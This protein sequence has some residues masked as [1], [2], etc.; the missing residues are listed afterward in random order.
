MKTRTYLS[1]RLE[2]LC[3]SSVLITLALSGGCE[4][5]STQKTTAVRPVKTMVVSAGEDVRIRSFP[6][7]VEAAKRVEL[8]FQVSGLLIELP[9]REGQE[10]KKGDLIGQI[11]KD[12]F[13]ARLAALQGQLDQARAELDALRLGERP[14]ERLR[15]E[16]QVRAA[17][18]RLA[19][20]RTERDR[21]APLVPRGAISRSELELLETQYQIAQE[22]LQAAQQM[23][24]K[25]LVARQEDLL[26]KEAQIRGLEG[27]VV[28]ANIQVNDCTLTAPFDGVIAQR[29]V[30]Q[31]QNVRAKEPIVRFQDAE[32]IEIAVDVP[33]AVMATD[34][35]RADILQLFAEI[36]GLPGMTFP[37]AIRE[38]A[39]VADPTVQTFNVRVAMPAPKDVRVLPGMTAT[40]TVDYRRASIL[41]DRILLPVSAVFQKPNGKQVVWVVGADEKV[42]ARPVKVGTVQG[43]EIQVTEGL[44]PGDRIAVAGAS[45]LREGMK[46]RDLGD[47]LG[48]S[49]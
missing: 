39:Q 9:V 29:F 3:S 28:E 27:R 4:P 17:Q 30:E 32:E 13:Q 15:R 6:G 21:V 31:G 41:G 11:R 47:A 2:Q 40:V 14:E 45:F 38:I 24:E 44:E 35:R 12:E 19:N 1:K 18:A 36:S 5:V 48:G 23:V 7:T 43:G 33:E 46:V 22:E 25:G 42:K 10:V 37:V 16:S 8:A 26:A 20:A 34:I 49:P